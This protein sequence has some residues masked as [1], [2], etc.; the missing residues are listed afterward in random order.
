MFFLRIQNDNQNR[1]ISIRNSSKQDYSVTRTIVDNVLEKEDKQ[2]VG[3]MDETFDS[4]GFYYSMGLGIT[5][6]PFK[7][8][9]SPLNG[10]FLGIGGGLDVSMARDDVYAEDY[11]TVG[12]IFTRYELGKD[13]W[14]SDTWSIGVG[15]SF[16]KMVYSFE[17]E[18]EKTDHHALSLFFRLTR[19]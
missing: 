2:L 9:T 7:D 17:N 10:I 5:V 13:W 16:S 1:K 6:Y 19:G 4:Y 8:P 14:V 11:C 3:V 12:G 15:V 18:G